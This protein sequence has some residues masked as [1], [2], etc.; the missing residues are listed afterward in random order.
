MSK[1]KGFAV[2]VVRFQIGQRKTKRAERVALKQAIEGI[3]P[4]GSLEEFSTRFL[5]WVESSKLEKQPRRC[6]RDGG[7]FRE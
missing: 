7:R 6:Y 2:L 1:K 5:S 4:L 3:K